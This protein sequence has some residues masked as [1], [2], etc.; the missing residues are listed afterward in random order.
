MKSRILQFLQTHPR[1][2]WKAR[3]IARYLKLGA[4]ERKEMRQILRELQEE[5]T[6]MG[7]RG[8]RY[9]PLEQEVTISGS[10]KV[11]SEGYAFLIPDTSGEKDVFIPARHLNGALPDDKVMASF[12][13]DPKTGRRE[14]RVL[15]VLTRIRKHW[16]GHLMRRGKSFYVLIDDWSPA[17][18]ILLHS[19]EIPKGAMGQLVAAEIT[20]Y[21]R[22]GQPHHGRI[23]SV[24]GQPQD[25]ET[26]KRVI[27]IKHQIDVDFPPEAMRDAKKCAERDFTSVQRQDLSSLPIITIDGLKARD[28]DDAV[29]VVRQGQHDH[30]YVSI[31]DVAH[32]VL[33]GSPLDKE[34]LRRG[35]SVYF[36]DFAV[37]MLPEILSNDLCSLKP[38]VPRPTLTAEISYD[39][40]GNAVEAWFYESV[41]KS[42]K[43]GIYEQVQ[44]YLDGKRISGDEFEPDVQ[45]NLDRMKDLAERLLQR[46]KERGSIDFDLPEPIVVFG[47]DGAVDN[48]V[49]AQR[50]F[51][52]RL[53]EEFMIAA[54][55]AVAKV[56]GHYQVPAL[57]RVHGVPERE[58]I[59]AFCELLKHCGVKAS[60]A[61]LSSPPDI[62]ALIEKIKGNPGEAM[63]HQALLRCMRIAVYQ[64]ENEGHFGLN[65]DDY[66]HFTS[67][68]R[69]YPD[70]IIH[71]QLKHLIKQ[72]KDGK[73]HLTFGRGHGKKEPAYYS[74]EKLAYFGKQSSARERKAME[75]EREMLDFRRCQLAQKMVGDRFTGIVRRVTKF[76]L[77][78]ELDPYFIEGLLHVRDMNDDYYEFDEKRLCLKGRKRKNKVYR[79]GDRIPVLIDR[80]SVE[81]REIGL[82][83]E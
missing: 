28:F 8:G 26:E 25:I 33:T 69:R 12:E 32:Y 56:L 64:P 24:V 21:G 66:A 15:R 62:A 80:V 27:L 6:L 46:R 82:A 57:Y 22:R 68:I 37:P 78:V 73:V 81:K 50:F 71:R 53:I 30:L 36:P 38:G 51:S 39:K 76:G 29:A 79:I 67:P 10:L 74:L 16:V 35:T 52:H 34:A 63:L 23:S 14:G 48:I 42:R 77:Y 11:H 13:E 49:R 5:G 40:Q 59:Q 9:R 1:H 2:A 83:I 47:S 43:R 54:N 61:Q 18:E 70:L 31:A 44:S 65:L 20:E 75:A 72:S 55:V 58:K 41:I 60:V 45:A 17:I 19:R 7:Q 4:E 3:E